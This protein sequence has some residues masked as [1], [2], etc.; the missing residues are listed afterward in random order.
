DD[1]EA[2]GILEVRVVD[3]L[4]RP[5]TGT[6][7]SVVDQGSGDEI[8]RVEDTSNS[9]A[10]FNLEQIPP[11]TYR[12]VVTKDGFRTDDRRVS[13]GVSR[14]I[15]SVQLLRLGQARG[16]IVDNITRNPLRNYAI[17]I[18]RVPS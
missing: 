14:V 10:T 4:N 13:V 7:V 3:A 12:L 9:Q 2:T 6:A 16:Q 5:L 17:D 11:G 15:E 18:F 8:R 1:F